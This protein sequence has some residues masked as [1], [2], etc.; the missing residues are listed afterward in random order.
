MLREKIVAAAAKRMIVIVDAGKQV[1]QLGRGP[2]PVEVLPFAAGFVSHRI[3]HLGAAV[4]LRM[5]GDATYRT[6]QDNVV[7]DCRFGAIDDPRALASA[8]S[9]IPGILGHGLF[10]DE[11]DVA[12]VGRSQGVTR[13]TRDAS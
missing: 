6:D 10:L 1:T 5:K 12:Y 4:S 11:I 3:E 9:T 13:L 2:L 8:L 7:L